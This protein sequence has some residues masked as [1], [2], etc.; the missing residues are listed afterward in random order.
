MVQVTC[1]VWCGQACLVVFIFY[2]YIF[3]FS[4]NTTEPSD[5]AK[6][7][8]GILDGSGGGA[9]VPPLTKGLG[10]IVTHVCRSVGEKNMCIQEG[11]TFAN[12]NGENLR[13]R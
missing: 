10:F 13:L 11:R 4:L 6:R 9:K 2:S 7:S 5:A 3:Y 1:N 8:G 12:D